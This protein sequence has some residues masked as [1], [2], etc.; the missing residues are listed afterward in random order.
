MDAQISLPA[1]LSQRFV[2]GASWSFIGTLLAQLL[3]MGLT[4]AV[5]HLFIK[6]E[7][8]SYI[9]LQTTLTT[10]GIFTGLGMGTLATRYA[11]ALKNS[12]RPR[13]GRVVTIGMISVAAFGVAV[14]LALAI[15]SKSIASE[16]LHNEKIG[17]L[18]LLASASV[19]F[20]SL[21]NYQKSVIIGFE[22]LKEVAI[23]SICGSLVAAIGIFTS[24]YFFGI[25]GAAAALSGVA[26]I[27]Y[28][29]SSLALRKIL[30]GYEMPVYQPGWKLEFPLVV[31]FGLPAL[32][33][34]VIVPA[35]M[36][37]V[38]TMLARS[39]NG[40]SELA[41]FGIAMQWFNALLFVPSVANKVLMPMLTE[42]VE[43]RDA[44]GARS[45]VKHALSVNF[46][47]T[48]L[49]V[50]GF[51]GLSRFILSAYGDVFPSGTY[52]LSI[53]AIAA[54]LASMMNVSGNLVSAHS[55]MW[56]GSLMNFGWA[57][58][59]IMFAFF[60]IQRGLGA[61]GVAT[62]LLLAYIAHFLWSA[63][64]VRSTIKNT[65]K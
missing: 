43:A 23:C 25:V 28:A 19:L 14:T 33:A 21:D 56:L 29:I 31:S 20:T 11:A 46:I 61:L 7:F 62:A 63:V 42:L 38:Q 59:Y 2:R 53:I 9:L 48:L 15:F 64:W 60:A 30:V 54:L 45:V 4:V 58:L 34:N 35:A 50:V 39:N 26:V 6:E 18:L 24:A 17:P 47:V 32:I 51:C 41:L 52:V 65:Y 1:S 49:M 10:L 13:L 57:V 16:M 37:V 3:L 5:S 8:G 44:D 55:R 36:W 12:D 27:Q 40:Y 22:R